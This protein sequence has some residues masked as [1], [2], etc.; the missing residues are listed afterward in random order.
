[1]PRNRSLVEYIALVSLLGKLIARL[2][3]HL[4][5]RGKFPVPLIGTSI[6]LLVCQVSNLEL[7]AYPLSKT[8]I[9]FSLSGNQR[10]KKRLIN[11]RKANLPLLKS[12]N[13]NDLEMNW[14]PGNC[15][16]PKT[17]GYLESIHRFSTDIS[18]IDPR[19]LSQTS[20]SLTPKLADKK[21][22]HMICTYERETVLQF[23]QSTGT[24]IIGTS[25][26]SNH[27]YGSLRRLI[28]E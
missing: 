14:K 26:L 22:N 4:S 19:R 2:F 8:I 11:E 9:G 7:T 1:M 23:Q 28:T 6:G 18:N 17:F 16:E 3:K 5:V 24:K 10:G 15:A 25:L 12:I 27:R 13:V 20:I 21:N